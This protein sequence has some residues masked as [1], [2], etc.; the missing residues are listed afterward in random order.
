MNA[1]VPGGGPRS[2][3]RRGLALLLAAALGALM[4]ARPA[5]ANA[6]EEGFQLVLY[7]MYV[8]LT[9]PFGMPDMTTGALTTVT[10]SGVGIGLDAAYALGVGFALKLSGG[11]SIH[12]SAIFD[13][14]SIGVGHANFGLSYS[15]DA[16][17]LVVTFDAAPGFYAHGQPDGTTGYEV[18]AMVGISIDYLVTRHFLVGVMLRYHIFLS[19]TSQFPAYFQVGPRF[20][21]QWP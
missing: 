17:R 14:R 2:R 19:N 12:P 18:G 8:G 10:A 13:G 6:L 9:G 11:Y 5:P 3:R 1:S 4:V 21:L 16:S 7:P 15:L 20:G